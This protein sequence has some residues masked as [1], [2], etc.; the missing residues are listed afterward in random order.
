MEDSAATSA[1]QVERPT[2]ADQTGTRAP[3]R[4][5]PAQRRSL[6]WDAADGPHTLRVLERETVIGRGSDVRIQLDDP[7]VSRRH[8]SVVTDTG[9]ARVRDLAAANGTFVNGE[10]IS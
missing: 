3:D 6:T 5:A 10:R 1:A 4:A 9:G 8:A 7:M 2:P